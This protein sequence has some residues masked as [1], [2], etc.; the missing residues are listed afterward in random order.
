ML[1]QVISYLHYFVKSLI[2][3]LDFNRL[4]MMISIV[5]VIYIL[6]FSVFN[7]DRKFRE[8]EKDH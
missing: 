3:I 6:M 1:R 2:T 7:L 4:L 5:M 8:S